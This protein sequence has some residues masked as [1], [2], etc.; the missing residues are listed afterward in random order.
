MGL[1]R[2]VDDETTHVGKGIIKTSPAEHFV[3]PIAENAE[4]QEFLTW[5]AVPNTPDAATA[6]NLAGAKR[7][8]KAE[9]DRD[10]ED[11]YRKVMRL[12]KAD[13]A[14]HAVW[15]AWLYAELMRYE[16][17]VKASLTPTAADYPCMAALITIEGATL[18]LV[19][20]NLRTYFNT[21]KADFAGIGG[22]LWKEHKA[23]NAAGSVAAARAI[24]ASFPAV[25]TVE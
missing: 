21:I 17:E 8:R 13:S 19:A 2:Y 12:Q 4:W 22:E 5:L 3:P 25:S 11:Q 23:I 1:Y 15:H 14:G 20:S 16:T 24:T 6:T 18:A 9:L 10:A 7:V